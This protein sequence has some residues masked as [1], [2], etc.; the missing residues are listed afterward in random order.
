MEFRQKLGISETIFVRIK[1]HI[2]VVCLYIIGC[3][4]QAKRVTE[5]S[6]DYACCVLLLR[7][8]ALNLRVLLLGSSRVDCRR[9][10]LPLFFGHHLVTSKV[11]R[12]SEPTA[13]ETEHRREDDKAV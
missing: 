7:I 10:I 1:R 3:D 11:W 12:R 6:R 4:A 13:A 5:L 9:L 8:A 2:I